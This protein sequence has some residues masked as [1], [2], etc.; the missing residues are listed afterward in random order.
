MRVLFLYGS[1]LKMA[2]QDL[3]SEPF[4]EEQRPGSVAGG[5]A[6]SGLEYLLTWE[7]P[8]LSLGTVSSGSLLLCGETWLD[9]P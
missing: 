9:L 7:P 1:P 3:R 6:L 5:G 8:C 4:F 2:F